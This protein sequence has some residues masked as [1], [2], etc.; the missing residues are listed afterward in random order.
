MRKIQFW[1]LLVGLVFGTMA[2]VACGGD[3][4]D[5]SIPTPPA[6]EKTLVGYW[7]GYIPGN[8][9]EDMALRYAHYL[10]YYFGSDNKY[11]LITSFFMPEISKEEADRYIQSALDNGKTTTNLDFNGEIVYFAGT[12]KTEG[13]QI[14]LSAKETAT[15]D[16]FYHKWQKT[17][18][19]SSQEDWASMKISY[20]LGEGS[21]TL[22]SDNPN[23]THFAY[24]HTL[25]GTLDRI[26]SVTTPDIP[27]PEEGLEINEENLQGTWDGSVDADFAQGYYQ[28]WRLKIE[29]KS[30]TSWHTHLTAG[31]INDEVQGV[32]TVGNKDQGTWEYKDGMLIL[33]PVKQWASYFLTAKSMNDPYYYV[34]YDYNPETM[35]S[36]PWYETPE[37]LTQEGVARDLEDGINGNEFYIQ[38]W[39]V[40]SLTKTELTVQ[41]NRDT[42]KLTKQ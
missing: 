11:W 24:H 40:V 25:V 16:S 13:N 31:S 37:Y 1:S 34:Y 33:T 17:V 8:N 7:K 20:S 3:D 23:I 18:N 29:G 6:T 39:P 36:D 5:D 21:L 26:Q 10:Y 28:R 32:K 9:P 42:F 12:Y 4:D 22:S 19:R 15:Y 35:E 41:I 2:F 14:L 27:D 30:Y 38:A